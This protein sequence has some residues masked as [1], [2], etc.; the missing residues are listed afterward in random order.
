MQVL[1]VILFAHT[2]DILYAFTHDQTLCLV[3]EDFYLS[4]DSTF[5]RFITIGMLT[6]LPCHPWK[7]NISFPV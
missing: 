7:C 6:L 2:L 5:Y 4:I 3:Y 1:G